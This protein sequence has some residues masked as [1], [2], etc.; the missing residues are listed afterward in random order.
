MYVWNS[1]NDGVTG[2]FGQVENG[3]KL[4]QHLF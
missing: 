3:G 1:N 4:H 2:L